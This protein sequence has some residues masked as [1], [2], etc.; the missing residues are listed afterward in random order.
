MGL[1][2]KRLARRLFSKTILSVVMLLLQVG[3]LVWLV[4]QFAQVGA[5]AYVIITI[6]TVLVVMVLM[7]KDD[8]NPAYKMIWTL[9][10]VLT[11][12]FWRR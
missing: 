8:L 11:P 9:L 1:F 12:I 2:W 7:N 4:L 10:V 5:L 3:V 6:I